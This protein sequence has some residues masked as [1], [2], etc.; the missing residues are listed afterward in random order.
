M[1]EKSKIVKKENKLE[2]KENKKEFNNGIFNFLFKNIKKKYKYIKG[3]TKYIF[4]NKKRIITIGDIH[5]DYQCLL[6]ALKL[7]N[8]IDKKITY[9]TDLEEIKWIAKKD[10]IVIQ[11]GDLIDMKVRFK[12]T[13]IIEK[14]DNLRIFKLLYNLQKEAILKQCKLICLLGN[15]EIENVLGNFKYTSDS[16]FYEFYKEYGKIYKDDDPNNKLGYMARKILFSR[17]NLIANH[18][19]K[20][21]CVIVIVNNWL[22]VHGG[23]DIETI[24]NYNFVDMNE[25][26]KK[27]LNSDDSNMKYSN[28]MNNL[29]FKSNSILKN[30]ELSKLKNNKKNLKYF[31]DILDSIKK[32][33][34]IDIKGIVIGHTPQFTNKKGINSEFNDKLWKIDVG[35]SSAFNNNDKKEDIYRVTQI[36]QIDNNDECIVIKESS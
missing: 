6:D 17:G 21:F 34:N 10:T 1:L 36:L 27:W 4:E 28:D 8:I 3:Y 25:I 24:E 35:M 11:I 13:N 12:N 32:Y 14:G 31:Q 23:I 19:S 22:F 20:N 33:N 30:R 15:H 29:F 18:F 5:G 7:G 2:D 26:Y 9:N 16:E